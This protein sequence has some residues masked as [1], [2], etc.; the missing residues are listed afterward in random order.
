MRRLLQSIIYNRKL[1]DRPQ[2]EWTC[3]RAAEG[4]P[5]VFGPGARGECRATSQCLPAKKGDRWVCT[6]PISLGAACKPGPLPDGACGCPVQPCRPVR[7]LRGQ[8]GRLVGLAAGA[9]L[10]VVLLALWGV[11]GTEWTNPGPLTSQHATSAQR[12]AD[13]HLES[14]GLAV[15]AAGT[16]ERRAAHD[17]LCLQCHDLGPHGRSPHGSDP[18][19]LAAWAGRATLTTVRP[20]AALTAARTLVR[21]IQADLACAAC[22][23]EHHGRDF[24]L[25]K[26]SD[27]QCQVCHQEQFA[28]FG[29]GHP[30][31]VHYPYVRR[32]RIRFDHTAHLQNHFALPQLA[33]RA[34][35]SC[36]SCHEP[37]GDGRQMLVRG[38]EQSCAR[39]HAAQIE[40]EGRPGAKGLVFLRLPAFD[41][42]TLRDAGESVG[43]WPA[44]CEGGVTPF[45][46]W[47]LEGDPAARAALA[48]L[49]TLNLA[50]LSGATREQKAAAA[51]LLWSIK[52]LLADLVTQGQRVMLRRLG[53]VAA[54]PVPAAR[55]TGQLPADGLLAA[56]QA[57]LPDL[58]AEVAAYRRGEKPALPPPPAAT[59]PAAVTLAPPATKTGDDDLLGPAAAP[60]AAAKPAADDL[61]AD[62]PTVPAATA[63]PAAA[64]PAVAPAP[65]EMDDAE[66][67]VAEG[68]WYRR[69]ETYALYYRPGG[70][71]DAFL[72]AWL[73]ATSGDASPAGRAIFAQLA[74]D[75]APGLCMK[76]HSVDAVK[77]Q[78]FVNWQAA[79][80][81]AGH[82][83][84]TTFKHAAHFSLM[85]DQGC[86]TCHVLDQNAAYATAFGANHNPAVFHSN[87]A[88]LTK[89]ACA[90]CH[91]PG[92]AGSACQQCHNYH[93]GDLQTLHMRAAD[94]QRPPPGI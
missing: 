86:K 59:Q 2:D 30:E 21:G 43:E 3:G 8:R 74:D 22:H 46:R 14:A 57:W 20:P 67:R 38:F 48:Q 10:G 15:T 71:A 41:L 31:F 83:E 91:Q 37:A 23:Q 88:P 16:A 84:F 11:H 75:Q 33:A 7:S 34:P 26:M 81:Q 6:R 28:S 49:G 45:M 69:D 17:R 1:Y 82:K 32:T 29:S 35:T 63:K 24:S 51:Q 55:R 77:G 61:L 76:C 12:C 85:G 9:A 92:G 66:M 89:A 42:A 44:F 64:T 47:M 79:L 39:C 27:Q 18:A 87:F 60:V 52:G 25:T 68:G 5:C 80:P 54:A 4:C 36:L 93:T 62:N 94:F 19:L 70:H 78:L 90:T 40:G 50:D 56:Q 72:T 53:P 13:C 73:D 65:M 58:L